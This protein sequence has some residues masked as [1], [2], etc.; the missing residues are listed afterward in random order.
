MNDLKNCGNVITIPAKTRDR[1]CSDIESLMRVA[2]YCRVSTEEDNQKNSYAAQINYYTE[3]IC[4]NPEWK[5]AGIFADEGISGTRTKNRKQF[6]NMI[7]MAR[8]KEIDIILCKSI[9]RF[10]RNTV[11]CLDYVRELKALGVT[12]IF[13]KET[14]NTS[15]VS[16]EFAISLYASFAQAESESISKNVVWGIEKSFREGNVRYQ[17]GRTLG[18]RMGNSGKPQ[19]VDE[20]AQTV[21]KIFEMYAEGHG[22]TEIANTLTQN[23]VARR[24]GSAVWKRFH[25]YQILRN[26]KYVGDALL[27]KTYTVNC[28]THE[29]AKN[30]GQKPMY[31]VQGCHDGIIDRGTYDAV[32]L[33]LEKRRRNNGLSKKSNRTRYGLSRRLV[34]PFC[35][36]FY[37][38]CT[39]ILKEGKV[40]M[41][42]CGGRMAGRKC[43]GSYSYRE[44]DL[45]GAIVNVLNAIIMDNE[46]TNDSDRLKNKI[47]EEIN[48]LN[49]NIATTAHELA[50]IEFKRNELLFSVS[51]S[52]IDK[53]SSELTDLNKIEAQTADKLDDLKHRRDLLNRD[54]FNAEDTDRFIIAHEPI[55]AF[56]ETLLTRFVKR[57]DAVSKHEILVT[58]ANG[59]IAHGAI[60]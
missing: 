50:A 35:G 40:G 5:L 10:A 27:Q 46:P 59:C 47:T 43:S 13:E 24:N 28:L 44:S 16:S 51:G 4:S 49:S 60:N 36:S 37:K 11:D 30:S 32:R 42:R 54:L 25:V 1:V 55:K 45:Q 33:E 15:T 12:V 9:S 58:L 6:N 38:R 52:T 7:A 34:C 23:G 29:R 3:Y 22:A 14:I 48:E 26:E 39:W 19:I 18:Y 8:K 53:V 57:I 20:E 31:L 17:L 56:D 2:A 41:W 21:R